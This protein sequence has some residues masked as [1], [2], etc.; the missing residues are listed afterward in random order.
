MRLDSDLNVDVRFLV[1][2]EA[3]VFGLYVVIPRPILESP[4]L[5]SDEHRRADKKRRLF[6][7]GVLSV[8]N[9]GL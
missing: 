9:S 1:E 4:T 6:L 2:R 8:V 5:A 7:M 3:S